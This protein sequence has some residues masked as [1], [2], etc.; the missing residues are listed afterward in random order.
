MDFGV[1]GLVGVANGGGVAGSFEA[2][3]WLAVGGIEGDKIA[4]TD[5]GEEDAIAFGNVDSKLGEG[6]GFGPDFLSVGLAERA[7]AIVGAE[8]DRLFAHL[9]G[10]DFRLK[11]VCPDLLQ[12]GSLQD[13]GDDGEEHCVCYTPSELVWIS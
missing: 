13:E 4:L 5:A 8:E 7:V 9:V 3:N 11:A 12:L 1:E 10:L 2:P 6:D